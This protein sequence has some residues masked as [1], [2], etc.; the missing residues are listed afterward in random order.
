MET[1]RVVTGLDKP[2]Q[3]VLWTGA[4]GKPAWHLTNARG[5]AYR[6]IVFEA[7]S[8]LL[9]AVLVESRRPEPGGV[10]STDNRFEH[11]TVLGHGRTR[12]GFAHGKLVA[13]SSGMTGE[14]LY[15]SWDTE[16]GGTEEAR[17]NEHMVYDQCSVFDT[18][19]A[20]F[21]SLGSQSKEHSWRDCKAGTY[22]G[23]DGLRIFGGGGQWTGGAMYG[24][25]RC[26]HLGSPAD[27]FQVIGGGYETFRQLLVVEGPRREPYPVTLQGLRVMTDG[28]EETAT[29]LIDFG[30]PGPLKI[31]G[32]TFGGGVQPLPRIRMR[33]WQGAPCVLNLLGVTFGAFGSWER[34]HEII[35][36]EGD[37]HIRISMAGVLCADKD[38]TAREWHVSD[39]NA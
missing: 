17:N 18:T 22:L 15:P 35:R 9:A 21:L 32:G 38:G 3:R 10:I 31:I 26:F 27:P 12:Y 29:L 16:D 14:V 34:R 6:D 23:G 33:S 2:T 19:D 36:Y 39:L 28:C 11:C 8:R 13:T 7:S 5:Q 37:G 4:E 1:T 30:G 20:A 25:D 24:F